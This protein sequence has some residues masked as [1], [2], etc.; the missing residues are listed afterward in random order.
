M[1]FYIAAID[2]VT[3]CFLFLFFKNFNCLKL[4]FINPY[5]W[6]FLPHLFHV[7]YILA[8]CIS[9]VHMQINIWLDCFETI[10]SNDNGHYTSMINH[11]KHM[12]RSV[13]T[14]CTETYSWKRYLFKTSELRS[15]ALIW[16][17]ATVYYCARF[18]ILYLL[19]TIK[20]YMWTSEQALYC[21]NT[22]QV[23]FEW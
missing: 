11:S 20:Y 23:P 10:L 4:Y 9:H 2:L 1:F 5:Y 12:L 14:V 7:D 17:L 3:N 16:F 6:K 21:A 19:S 15:I 13:T 18:M 22:L 8:F